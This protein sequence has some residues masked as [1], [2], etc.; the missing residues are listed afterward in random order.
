MG[1]V[2]L[3]YRILAPFALVLLAGTLAT[4]WATLRVSSEALQS[5]VQSQLVNAANVAARG[6]LALNPAILQTF[7]QILDADLVTLQ[8]DAVLAAAVAPGER[9]D[10]VATIASTAIR[11]VAGTAT[12]PAVV[13]SDCGGVPCLVAL[14]PLDGRPDTVVALVAETSELGR[15]TR[16]V[17]RAAIAAAT[18]SLLVMIVLGQAVLRRV[19]APLNRLVEF[20]RSSPLEGTGRRAAVSPGEVGTLAEAFN[21]MLDRLEGSQAALVRSEKLAVA[22]LFAARVAHDIRNPLSSIKMQAQLLRPTLRGSPDDEAMLNAVLHD[23]DQVESVIRDLLELARP[24]ELRLQPTDINALVRDALGRLQAQFNH[25]HVSV[26]VALDAALPRLSLDESRFRQVLLNV[27]LNASE[28]MITGGALHVETRTGGPETVVLEVC[29][30]GVGVDQ[31]LGDR[32]FEPFVST[33]RDGVG[34]GLVNAKAVVEGHGGRIAISPRQPKGTCVT[35]TLPVA[36]IQI[37]GN[38]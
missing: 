17:T 30:D 29:D 34:L 31:T 21:G 20:A 28:A 27:L 7:R 19:T 36:G 37:N 1:R 14:R 26:G 18:A 13:Q 2:S 8:G 5:R 23:V 32:V 15:A 25:R 16:A 12:W 6:D 33:K 9:V 4:A 11:S 10:R 3:H 22:G 35:I 38:G 24:G